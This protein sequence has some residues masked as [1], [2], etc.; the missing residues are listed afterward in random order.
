[1]CVFVCYLCVFFIQSEPLW[2]ALNNMRKETALFE[3]VLVLVLVL[4]FLF[5][6][7]F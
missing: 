5:I 1:M 6:C 4:V 7:S 2:A 3:L